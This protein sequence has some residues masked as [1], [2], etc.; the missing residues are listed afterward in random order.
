MKQRPQHIGCETQAVVYK[1]GEGPEPKAWVPMLSISEFFR[2]RKV[3]CVLS[4]LGY[5]HRVGKYSVVKYIH[6]L[7]C[8]RKCVTILTVG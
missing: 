8:M 4:V 7:I 6:V 3:T 1:Y 5:S 2:F